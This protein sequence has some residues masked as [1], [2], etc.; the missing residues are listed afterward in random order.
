MKSLRTLLSV[1]LLCILFVSSFL[2]PGSAREAP[3]YTELPSDEVLP[4]SLTVLP[5]RGG[6]FYLVSSNIE[7]THISYLEGKT[8]ALSSFY[9]LDTPYS[10]AALQGDCL[11]LACPLWREEG[12][13][14]VFFS[15]IILIPLSGGEVR[16][17]TLFDTYIQN[18][19][20][21][22]LLPD[23]FAAI[24]SQDR[25][26]IRRFD[27]A[28]NR[29]QTLEA[30]GELFQIAAGEAGA[31]FAGGS[32][33]TFYVETGGALLPAQ[34]AAVSQ[35]FTCLGNSHLLGWEG[36]L[37]Q[38]PSENPVPAYCY[39]TFVQGNRAGLSAHGLVLFLSDRLLLLDTAS[40]EAI[41]QIPL[42]THD[43]DLFF[44][45]GGT[46]LIIREEAGQRNALCIPL[47]NPDPV[48]FSGITPAG[49]L[50]LEEELLS[51]W[52]QNLPQCD[53]PAG[54]FAERP[55]LTHFSTPGRVSVESLTDG[56]QAV[57][58][59][60][61]TY[62]L[63][64]L[65]YQ[66]EGCRTLQYGAVLSL[67]RQEDGSFLPPEA[68]DGD[69]YEIGRQALS[70]D[71]VFSIDSDASSPTADAVHRLFRESAAFRQAIL[72]GEGSL[73][74]AC[75]PLEDGSVRVLLSI[76]ETAAPAAPLTFPPPGYYPAVLAQ[77]GEWSAIVPES[78]RI[79]ERGA[80]TAVITDLTDG[81]RT[82]LSAGDGLSWEGNTLYLAPGQTTPGHRYRIRVEHLTENGLPAA[83]EWETVLSA[84]TLEPPVLSGDVNLD[85]EVSSAD[86][87]LL[88][89]YLLGRAALSAQSLAAA[90]LTQDG[91]VNTIDLLALEKRLRNRS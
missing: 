40:G 83:L 71:Y 87:Q 82:A 73:S 49:G 86:Q 34:E 44:V 25:S 89:D 48:E 42:E 26:R 33:G 3:A 74:L 84:Q 20:D 18:Q 60:R 8:G 24:D 88:L 6:G 70:Q 1:F 50:M 72:T 78:V 5:D 14:A 85:G 55:D 28:G 32:Q 13:N 47:D 39:Q 68:M 58:F 64:S 45:S 29:T 79:G 27:L 15:R 43:D 35:P 63:P 11:A 81:S 4:D 80:P 21:F 17:I 31:L 7:Q 19:L 69:F 61:S 77:T 9:T 56:L 57:H 38:M 12:D 37:W 46:A 53:D 75:A 52:R 41:G 36:D 59:Y 66:E 67:Y 54:L 10:A 2:L 23:G 51:L 76:R 91:A 16:E 90:D 65:S 62:G 30:E 22:A